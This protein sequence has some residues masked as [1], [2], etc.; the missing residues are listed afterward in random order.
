[1]QYVRN[2]YSKQ[3]FVYLKSILNWAPCILSGKPISEEAA[4]EQKPDG[5]VRFREGKRRGTGFSRWRLVGGAISKVHGE[6]DLQG[7]FRLVLLEPEVCAQRGWEAE[8]EENVEMEM[9][10]EMEVI[11]EKSTAIIQTFV[12]FTSPEPA[13]RRLEERT[14]RK[15]RFLNVLEDGKVI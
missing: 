10:M 13:Q 3:A 4:F 8:K 7:I 15:G 9:E 11:R 6:W 14:R 5:W 1:M 2:T 12:R